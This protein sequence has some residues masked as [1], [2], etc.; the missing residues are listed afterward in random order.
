MVKLTA[1]SP[2]ED[3]LPIMIGKFSLS[4]LKLGPM[5]SIAPYKG[6]ADTVSKL[7]TERYELGFPA[8]NRRLAKGKTQVLW[9][10]MD[11]ALLIGAQ[12]DPALAEHAAMTDQS[13]AWCAV[14]LEGEGA[15]DVLARLVSVDLRPSKF[16]RGHTA[17]CDLMHM[18]ASVTKTGSKTWQIMVFRS[19]AKTL[20][21]DLQ[22]AM[23]SV[24]AR[25]IA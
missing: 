15:E 17:R 24:K 25:V 23:I 10:G 20:V 21:H 6:Q 8:P 5:T 22:T 12:P 2:C 7:L 11:Q 14:K 4:E 18:M 16:K 9:F 1:V 19:M 3:V 13:D